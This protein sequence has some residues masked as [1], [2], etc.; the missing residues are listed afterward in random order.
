[1]SELPQVMLQAD[2]IAD[3]KEIV[4]DMA[5]LAQTWTTTAGTTSWQ[6]LIGQ[7]M[8]SQDLTVGGYIERVS[9]EVR[10]VAASA[11]WTTSYSV[12]CAAGLASGLIPST[13]AIGQTLVAT[14][15]NNRKYRIEASGYKPGSAW[16]VLQVR[17][18]DSR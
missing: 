5:D 14:E 18:E 7:P 17:A 4:G 13:L 2:L 1:M 12:A 3:A 15:Q 9:F 6:V 16:V 11:S 8:I 10:I